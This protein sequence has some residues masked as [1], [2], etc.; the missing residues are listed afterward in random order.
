MYTT[1]K[2][3]IFGL[4]SLATAVPSTSNADTGALFA[5]EKRCT[6]L[7]D[8]C[9]N[10]CCGSSTSCNYVPICHSS[11]CVSYDPTIHYDP[12]CP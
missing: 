1:L 8:L 10:D 11:R 7:Y 6:G 4:L 9:N 12:P 3:A 2:I 5:I